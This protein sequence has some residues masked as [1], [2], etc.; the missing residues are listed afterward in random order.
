MKAK[1]RGGRWIPI[2]ASILL[3]TGAAGASATT[4][5]RQQLLAHAPEL[6]E[7]VFAMRKPGSDPHWYANFGYYGPD[8]E[9]VAHVPGG[10]LCK[11]DLA[12][13]SVTTLIDDPRG[14][15]RDP[16][17]GHDAT[18]IVFSWRRDTD[19]HFHLYECALDGSG[20][21]QLTD[22]P[23]DDIEPCILP[24]DSLVFVSSRCKRWVNCWLTQVATL[25]RCDSD[26]SNIEPISANLEHDNTPWPLP[27]GRILHQRWEYI[28]RSQV[29]YHHLWTMN[30]DGTNA[31]AFFGNQN[32]GV[33]MIDA[34]PVPGGDGEV[35][36]IFSPGHGKNE[37]AGKVVTLHPHRGPDDPAAARVVA[38]DS[39]FRDPW[40]LASGAFLVARGPELLAM[41]GDGA[42]ERLHI[43]SE[44]ERGAGF[45]LHEP[46]PVLPRP[47]E[48]VIPPR[49][50]RTKATGKL[51]LADILEG[52]KMEGV[53]PG[54][55][56]KLLVLESLPKPINYTGGMDPLSY[57]GSFTLERVLGTVPVEPD[58]SAYFEL[59]ARRSLF[60]VALDENDFAVKRM[61]SFLT[62]QPGEV[63]SCV[64]CHEQRTRTILPG[65]PLQALGRPPSRITP[66]R[67]VPEVFDFPRDIQPILDRACVDCHGYDATPRGGPFDGG[68]VLSGDRGPMFSH[69]YFTLTIEGLFSDGRNRAK[70]NYAPRTL[71]SS[72]SRLFDYLDGSHHDVVVTP[73]ER[74]KLRLWIEAAATYPG[75]YAALGTGMIGG[76]EEN[77]QVE[78][79]HDWPTT[80]KG[81][82]VID[83]RCQTC[84]TRANDPPPIPRSLSDER[85]VSFWMPGIPNAVH[86]TSRHL[87][88]NLSRP[89]KSLL[90]LAPLSCEAGGFG[91][92]V[93]AEGDPPVF[94]DRS[95]P[96]YRTLLAM[97]AAGRDRLEAITR[98][99]M[100]DFRPRSAYLREMKRFGILPADLAPDARPD[101]YE[102]DERYWQS[103]WYRP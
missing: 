52:R 92:C 79:D 53:E 93:R 25:H 3:V 82:E 13:G 24:D 67:D 11:L 100:P 16:V 4:T 5:P 27:D 64:G 72:A 70:S 17:L 40:A 60:L 88:F 49:I 94:T 20:L 98:F 58:G 41:D 37:H 96:D 50:D 73:L 69:S 2:G 91:L 30:P 68:L 84:H 57:G 1:S 9:R 33:V 36:S 78:T 15:I 12:G 101:P 61:Q 23:W 14:G 42:T 21:R 90:L 34:K 29:H 56:R 46:R 44:E 18:R 65:R 74:K 32:P 10:R 28:D 77:Q 26:G 63:T 102:L 55:I 83:R 54:E 99:D 35:V 85:N 38:D 89:E 51:I 7:I 97:V 81:A 87:V 6:R 95:D 80:R 47:R 31:M 62:V 45:Q 86:A 76:Y 103:L 43:L 71:G 75:T 8:E 59:P 19:P 39:E 48:E 66:E 22:G